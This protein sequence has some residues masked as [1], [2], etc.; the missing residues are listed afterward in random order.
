MQRDEAL[1][2]SFTQ[3]GHEP[4]M[5]RGMNAAFAVHKRYVYIG[6]R[7]DG[8]NNNANH[9]GLF[10]VDAQDP[11]HP[12]IVKEIGPPFEGNPQESSR[13]LRV[14]RSQ[15]VLVVLQTCPRSP[16]TTRPR[17]SNDPVSITF[18]QSIGAGDALRTGTYSKTLTFALST[19]NP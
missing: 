1:P 15:N 5:G 9:A 4:L 7:T 3:I 8:K 14:W 16:T 11:A 2:G 13:E 10:V 12:Q 6:S 17:V 19:T 18:K